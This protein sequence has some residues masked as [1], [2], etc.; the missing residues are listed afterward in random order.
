MEWN[1][2]MLAVALVTVAVIGS[3]C[4]CYFGSVSRETVTYS[5]W[6]EITDVQPLYTY[7][8][9]PL[10]TEY[11]PVE[12][13][14]GWDGVNF[15]ISPTSNRYVVEQGYDGSTTVTIDLSG[16]ETYRDSENHDPLFYW[17]SYNYYLRYTENGITTTLNDDIT[18][19]PLASRFGSVTGNGTIT[20]NGGYLSNN[21]TPTEEYSVHGSVNPEHRHDIIYDVGTTVASATYTYATAII[22]AYDSNNQVLW[23]ADLNNVYYLYQSAPGTVTV[24]VP[25]HLPPVYMDISDGVTL[26]YNQT[27]TWS[28]GYKNGHVSLLLV[29][30][31]AC[32]IEVK[33]HLTGGLS[34]QQYWRTA[35]GMWKYFSTEIGTG[36]GLL[37][38]FDLQG[39]SMSFT[40]VLSMNTF[41]D[42]TLGV[43]TTGHISQEDADALWLDS[44]ELKLKSPTPGVRVG[45]VNT[46]LQLGAVNSTMGN[47]TLNIGN[48]F[49]QLVNGGAYRVDIG[50]PA[51]VGNGVTVFG[52]NIPITGGS[53]VW[54]GQHKIGSISCKVEDGDAFVMFNSD[55]RPTWIDLGSA[56][57]SE[58]AF[59]GE[60]YFDST[61]IYEPITKTRVDVTLGHG[62]DMS[63]NSVMLVAI[64]ILVAFSL[65]LYVKMDYFGWVNGVIVVVAVA[66]MIYMLV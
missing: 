31:T 65:I 7:E 30:E 2:G 13:W 46:E 61:I 48:A 9:V 23:S 18:I 12:N 10:Y 24:D 15:N 37:A 21:G 27:A 40:P 19:V 6:N 1:R 45:V 56:T 53:Y 59:S 4:V 49:P 17:S 42:F 36:V 32:N 35:E 29:S 22:T 58:I 25:N 63:W 47:P 64:G 57:D 44:L 43:T 41:A 52:H 38:D 8:D 20:I 28:N 54:G 39:K 5:E 50:S 62:E 14:T 55:A 3:L 33:M 34:T 66:L 51:V 60:W 26:V 16:G 11:N